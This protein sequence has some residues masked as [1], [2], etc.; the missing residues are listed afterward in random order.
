MPGLAVGGVRVS[1]RGGPPAPA[2]MVSA[3]LFNAL[4]NVNA[5]LKQIYDQTM[6]L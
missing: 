4:C 2:L 5:E 3:V 1:P 6:V